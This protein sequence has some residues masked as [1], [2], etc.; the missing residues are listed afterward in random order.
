M[1]RKNGTLSLLSK[2]IWYFVIVLAICGGIYLEIIMA[3]YRL[4]FHLNM[5]KRIG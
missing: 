5:L 1:G 2:V 4:F 3:S